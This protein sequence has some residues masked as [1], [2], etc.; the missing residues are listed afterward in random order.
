MVSISVKMEKYMKVS[1]LII[2]NLVMAYKFMQMA[3]YTLGSSKI[4]K[5]TVMANSF[6]L[7]YRVKTQNK[8][9]L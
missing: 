1:S 3:T 8:T 2:K 6:G 7:I 5:S 4:V 9:N